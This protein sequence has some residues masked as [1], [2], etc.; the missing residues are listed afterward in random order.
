MF[1]EISS[2]RRKSN[3]MPEGHTIHRIARDHRGWFAGQMIGLC[4]PQGR[5]AQESERLDG[6]LLQDVTAHGKHLF[7]HW[8]PQEIVHVH[9]QLSSLRLHD[10]QLAVGPPQ[11]LRMREVSE[12]EPKVLAAHENFCYETDVFRSAQRKAISLSREQRSHLLFSDFSFRKT[13]ST[14]HLQPVHEFGK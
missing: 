3:L 5:F 6:S 7:Y 13:H 10:R 8:S 14:S 4:S 9:L 12:D 1:L 11:D 2:E